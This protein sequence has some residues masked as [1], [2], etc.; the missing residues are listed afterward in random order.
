M[1]VLNDYKTIVNPNVF[2]ANISQLSAL[3]GPGLETRPARYRYLA[4]RYTPAG[5]QTTQPRNSF[6]YPSLDTDLFLQAKFTEYGLS[7]GFS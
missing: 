5:C 7:R 2:G 4:R 3:P 6:Y 1:R